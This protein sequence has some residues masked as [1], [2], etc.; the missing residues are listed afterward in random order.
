MIV[1]AVTGL[2]AAVALPTFTDY[3]RKSRRTEALAAM[4]AIQHAQ[5]RWRTGHPA[6]TTSWSDLA[7]SS[8]TPSGHYTLALHAPA[9]PD[10][11]AIGFD[12]VATATAEQARD[13]RCR[14]LAME[15]RRGQ[16]R[17]GSGSGSIDW[18][19][20]NRCWAR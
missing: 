3:V 16:L 14:S 15:L 19:D 2:L 9:A 20:P 18:A 12:L 6:Y 13:T 4:A 10:T 11:L 5:E 1:L 7:A 17:Y 8:V